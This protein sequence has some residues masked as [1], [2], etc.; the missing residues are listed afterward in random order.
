[1]PT[2]PFCLKN[3]AFDAV[4]CRECGKSLKDVNKCPQCGAALATGAKFCNKC[5]AAA[6]K[7]CPQCGG[8]L[9]L[10]AKFCNKC[11]G[12]LPSTFWFDANICLKCNAPLKP[13]ALFCN[14][15]GASCEQAKA[16]AALSVEE[17]VSS[18]DDNSAIVDAL[19]KKYNIIDDSTAARPSGETCVAKT[20][21]SALQM[22]TQPEKEL[23]SQPKNEPEPQSD[24]NSAQS[25]IVISQKEENIVAVEV[26]KKGIKQKKLILFVAAAVVVIGAVVVMC[27]GGGTDSASETVIIDSRDGHKYKTVKI[28]EQIWMA[29]NLNYGMDNSWCYE[30]D[31]QNC[32]RFGRL[33]TWNS[34]LNACP[35]GWSL[36]SKYDWES[37]RE[38]VESE[39]G[40]GKAGQILKSGGFSAQFGGDRFN[41]RYQLLDKNG[42]YWS[43]TE[44]DEDRAFDYVFLSESEDFIQGNEKYAL[45]GNG[46]SVR[47]KK[48]E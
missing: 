36:P 41:G 33:Y 34:A 46:F 22:S 39:N 27:V 35:K 8:P 45:K 3:V 6:P 17:D 4:F 13:G 44:I 37:L 26:K 16:E 28:G 32:Q 11:G 12:S 23:E 2:C 43:S 9:I 40:T 14:K 48:S 29:E 1:M 42:Y 15:C 31:S 25:D 5:G 20:T 47:C 19:L 10:G 18:G 38:I 21:E 30:D 24:E 7:T